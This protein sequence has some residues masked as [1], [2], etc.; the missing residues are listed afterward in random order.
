M[1]S[2]HHS[3]PAVVRSAPPTVVI[4]P[5]TIALASS[6]RRRFAMAGMVQSQR[7]SWKR[8]LHFVM[9]AGMSLLVALVVNDTAF[10]EAYHDAKALASP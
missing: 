5:R 4:S 9:G 2:S 3:V 1:A 7:W 8:R 10:G 6:V